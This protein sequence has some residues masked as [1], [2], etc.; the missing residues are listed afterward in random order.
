MLCYGAFGLGYIIPATFLPVMAR[1]VLTGRGWFAWAWPLF[2][3]AAVS[4]TIVAARIAR[5]FTHRRIWIVANVVMAAGV[6]VPIVLRHAF[7][8]AIA[9]LCVGGTFMVITMAGIQEARRVAGDQARAVIGAMTAAFA[10]GQIAGPLLVAALVRIPG[11]FSWALALSA[12]PLLVAAGVLHMRPSPTE[13]V[14]GATH[15]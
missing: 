3:V 14:D 15:A 5:R 9:A 10:M 1:E 13:S 4:S 11:G 6:L 2:G 12:I 7:G 8:V